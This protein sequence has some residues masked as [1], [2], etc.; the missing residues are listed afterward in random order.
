MDRSD[1]IHARF[2]KRGQAYELKDTP[3]VEL[4]A[5]EELQEQFENACHEVADGL[6]RIVVPIAALSQASRILNACV[7][8]HTIILEALRLD[9][10]PIVGLVL[11]RGTPPPDDAERPLLLT[12]RLALAYLQIDEC[13]IR[14]RSAEELIRATS[15]KLNVPAPAG[16]DE[17]GQTIDDMQSELR[18]LREERTNLS[19]A[20][21]ALRSQ[22]QALEN[23]INALRSRHQALEDNI[24]ALNDELA[25]QNAELA[26]AAAR[27]TEHQRQQSTM[28]EQLAGEKATSL[29]L[30]EKLTA[31][32]LAA[33]LARL[34]GKTG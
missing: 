1:F 2:G 28:L 8:T 26:A 31:R 32:T 3:V 25:Q 27:A 10:E 5:V 18:T 6:F 21:E 16:P 22:H 9:N 23:N 11:R 33:R 13:R 29:R 20:N 24:A 7:E 17:I 14:Y 15:E 12:N 30:R 19:T 34:L 4:E